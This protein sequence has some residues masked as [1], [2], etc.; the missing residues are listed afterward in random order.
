MPITV[1]AFAVLV[2]VNWTSATLG[3]DEEGLSYAQF[4][5]RS[6]SHLGPGSKRYYFCLLRPISWQLQNLSFLN[7]LPDYISYRCRDAVLLISSCHFTLLHTYSTETVVYFHRFWVHIGMGY[8]FTFWTFYVL[9][10]EYKVITTMRLR[11]LANQ[12]RRPDQFTVRNIFF[13]PI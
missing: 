4:D 1:L 9:Y 5:K 10:H 2:P 7:R 11:F 8:V 13:I 3:D 12:S 6:I